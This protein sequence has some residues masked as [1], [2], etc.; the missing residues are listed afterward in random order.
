MNMSNIVKIQR[1][2]RCHLHQKLKVCNPCS[3]PHIFQIENIRSYIQTDYLTPGRIEYYESTSTSNYTLEDGFMEYIVAK[4]I[5]GKR[6][7]EGHSPIDVINELHQI[8]IDVVCLNCNGNKTNEKS[9][10]QNFNSS[11]ETLDIL[12]HEE[13]YQDAIEMYK[14]DYYKKIKNAINIYNLKHMYYLIFI[15]IKNNIYL[16]CFNIDVNAVPNIKYDKVTS[17]SIKVS[18]FIDDLFGDV[19]LYI[20][21]KRLELRLNKNII[22]HKNTIKLL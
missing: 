12:F 13:K 2:F 14:L 4:S 6:V 8:G 15:S 10:M 11:G 19:K 20:S 16:S 1:W 22:N 5:G 3:I 9:I 21:K 7:G 18:N 17:K